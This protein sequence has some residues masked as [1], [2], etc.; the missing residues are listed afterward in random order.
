MT[1]KRKY[2]HGALKEA[3]VE[4]ALELIAEGGPAS[5]SLTEAAKRVG[6]T[7]A[8]PYR[9]FASRDELLNEVA[10]RGFLSFGSALEKAWD[11]GRPDAATAMWRMCAGYL[12]FARLEPGLYSAMFGSVA[13]LSTEAS[14][15]AAD[16]A[17]DILWRSVVALLQ[18]RGAPAQGARKLAL[19]LWALAHGVAMLSISGHLDAAKGLDPVPVLDAAARNLMEAAIRRAETAPG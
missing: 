18:Q 9:H 1:I 8:A 6:V 3:L 16:H 17:L 5:L 15:D 2:H 7:A 12:A 10:R 4:A 19:Q 14:A 11:E 13:T